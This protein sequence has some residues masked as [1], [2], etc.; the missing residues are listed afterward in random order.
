[1]VSFPLGALVVLYLYMKGTGEQTSLSPEQRRQ[2]WDEVTIT[3]FAFKKYKLSLSYLHHLSSSLP[4]ILVISHPCQPLYGFIRLHF[5]AIIVS[6]SSNNSDGTRP[7]P[8][9]YAAHA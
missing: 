4:L 8:R 2:R 9:F 3:H 1:M 7:S 6:A 5:P